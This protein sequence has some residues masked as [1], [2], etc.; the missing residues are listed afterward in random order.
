MG[1]KVPKPLLVV[2]EVVPEFEVPLSETTGLLSQAAIGAPASI[3]GAGLYV[4]VIVEDAPGGTARVERVEDN[5]ALGI[6]EGFDK[7]PG[8]VENDRAFAP[9][10]DLPGEFS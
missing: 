1:L 10:A 7:G 2:Q 4:I 8:K 6:V 5:I 3:V 9:F